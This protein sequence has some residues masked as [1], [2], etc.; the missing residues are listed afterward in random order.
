[1]QDDPKKKPL[2]THLR[3]A[4]RSL[5]NNDLIYFSASLKLTK[6]N[7]CDYLHLQNYFLTT[8]IEVVSE[9]KTV[10][11]IWQIINLRPRRAEV[12]RTFHKSLII[13]SNIYILWSS[14]YR[15][16]SSWSQTFLSLCAS[17]HSVTFI[18]IQTSCAAVCLKRGKVKSQFQPRCQQTAAVT[19]ETAGA[20]IALWQLHTEHDEDSR[21]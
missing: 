3:D 18:Y 16:V 20:G 10:V 1:M 4:T 14:L 2:T 6:S 19:P 12:L 8:F 11:L 5:G 21:I 15:C 7:V 17:K 9:G 13:F